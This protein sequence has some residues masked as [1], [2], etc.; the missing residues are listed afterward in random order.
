MKDGALNDTSIPSWMAGV[1]QGWAIPTRLPR[2]S[3]AGHTWCFCFSRNDRSCGSVLLITR[4][5]DVGGGIWCLRR[6][7]A[8]RWDLGHTIPVMKCGIWRI[9]GTRL[10]ARVTIYI[11]LSTF[12]RLVCCGRRRTGCRVLICG[13]RVYIKGWRCCR[14]CF[15]RNEAERR[16]RVILSMRWNADCGAWEERDCSPNLLMV[17]WSK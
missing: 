17:L 3:V 5:V 16:V 7:L 15:C 8:E 4:D 1:V 10:T 14:W 12:C 9:G 11:W 6:N 2:G 13:A